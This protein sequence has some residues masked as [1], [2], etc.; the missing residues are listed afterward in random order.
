[1]RRIKSGLMD[2]SVAKVIKSEEELGNAEELLVL[3]PYGCEGRWGRRTAYSRR[4]H[5]RRHFVETCDAN[6]KDE[7]I[8]A[9]VESLWP[10]AGRQDFLSKTRSRRGRKGFIGE[11]WHVTRKTCA[12]RRKTH[13]PYQTFT[14]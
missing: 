14:H 2:L 13:I 3:C 6:L 11:T 4:E 12:G 1:M 8:E 9:L 5:L 7:E 10:K